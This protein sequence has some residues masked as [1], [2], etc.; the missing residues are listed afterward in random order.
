MVLFAPYEVM[1]PNRSNSVTQVCHNDP[2]HKDKR[3]GSMSSSKKFEEDPLGETGGGIL[4]SS[5]LNYKSNRAWS[6]F[7]ILV[8]SAKFNVSP[9]NLTKFI[10]SYKKLENL[11][12]NI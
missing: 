11:Q 9:D 7:K 8:P 3:F 6:G 1:S 4:D 10:Y 12:A 2:H 5:S